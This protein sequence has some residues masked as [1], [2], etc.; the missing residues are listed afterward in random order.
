MPHQYCI[1]I[2]YFSI[3]V[4][5][6]RNTVQ[7]QAP[8]DAPNSR[9]YPIRWWRSASSAL[10]F[11]SRLSSVFRPKNAVL[12][13]SCKDYGADAGEIASTPRAMGHGD[14]H[15]D[16]GGQV[17]VAVVQDALAVKTKMAWAFHR[18]TSRCTP[19][20]R[21]ASTPYAQRAKSPIPLRLR[22]STPARMVLGVDS[23]LS[24]IRTNHPRD[25]SKSNPQPGNPCHTLAKRQQPPTLVSQQSAV[26]RS[27]NAN[28]YRV[29]MMTTR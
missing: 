9:S 17:A 12:A 18:A 15:A 24:S 1:S 14:S 22:A 5:R 25:Q 3:S 27:A 2:L 21:L 28:A 16:A 23:R 8:T 11:T 29:S 19:S 6:A 7:R 13:F 26:L 20:T 4:A 10:T